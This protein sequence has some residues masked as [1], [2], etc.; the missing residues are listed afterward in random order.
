MIGL[1]AS[2]KLKRLS[3]EVIKAFAWG[4]GRYPPKH[5]SVVCVPNES[6]EI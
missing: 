1:S 3:K 2:N 6:C 5:L 4:N